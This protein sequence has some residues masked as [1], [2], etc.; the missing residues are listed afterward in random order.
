MKK[1]ENLNVI[2]NGIN[3][4]YIKEG[5]GE[6]CII[7]GLGAVVIRCLSDEMKKRFCF[8]SADLAIL[9]DDPKI[10]YQKMSIESMADDIE[11]FRQQLGL[12]QVY[13]MVQSAPGFVALE[14]VLKYP[15]HVKGVIL[16]GSR[17]RNL[18]NENFDDFFAN[19]ASLERKEQ[20]IKDQERY[21]KI[22]LSGLSEHEKVVEGYLSQRAKYFYDFKK[23]YHNIWENINVNLKMAQE[24]HGRIEK[25]YDKRQEYLKIKT[26]IFVAMGRYDYAVPYFHWLE[27]SKKMPNLT[28][29]I[30]EK[31][32][33]Y[34]MLEEQD[35]F[36][37]KI[38]EWLGL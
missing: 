34:P 2:I 17:S 10:D 20:F 13:L 31:S 5:S 15:S 9:Q 32:A 30:F 33:H 16:I 26:K 28:L 36:D 38:V 14:Y 35:L 6:P 11:A 18:D 19:D 4:P 12:D 23:D 27:L 7:V 25:N 29:H 1:S 37:R 22:D 21:Q 8:Y 24:F 3:Y